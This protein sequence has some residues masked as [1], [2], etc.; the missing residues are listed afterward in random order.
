MFLIKLKVCVMFFSKDGCFFYLGVKIDV[1]KLQKQY[2][3]F[4]NGVYILKIGDQGSI[5]G[6]LLLWKY[7]FV[8]GSVQ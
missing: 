5:F 3:E 2:C 8:F 1:D 4:Y 6:C 7:M